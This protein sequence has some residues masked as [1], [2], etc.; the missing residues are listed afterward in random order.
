MAALSSARNAGIAIGRG[1]FVCFLDA[2]DIY[3]PDKL[4][5]QV[6]FLNLFPSCD[7]VYSDHYVGDAS[8]TPFQLE[9]R[10]PPPFP[11][12]MSLRTGIGSGHITARESAAHRVGGFDE[13]LRSAEDWDLWIE[14]A[15]AGRSH[16]C[17]GRSRCTD[18]SVRC[19]TTGSGCAATRI[20]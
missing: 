4:E 11:C 5:R 20:A 12:E 18:V 13:R 14:R 19:T 10:R 9:C 7:L 15:V 8:L 17:R 3:L 6:A 2:D 1:E 16:I